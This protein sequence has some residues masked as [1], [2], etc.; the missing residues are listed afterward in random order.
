M[1]LTKKMGMMMKPTSEVICCVV[2]H[3]LFLPIALKLAEQMGKVYYWSPWDDCAPKV[4]K[5]I[6]GD[7]FENLHR[8][9]SIWDIK[10]ECD[11]FVFPDVGFAGLQKELVSQGYAVWGHH[12]ADELETKRGLFL[13]TLED[14]GMLVPDYDIVL[15][16]TKLREFLKDKEDLWI[17]ISRWRGDWETF[18]WRDW[19]H[20]EVTLDFY[21]YHFGPAKELIKFYVFKTIDTDI[22]DGID[23]YC[24]DDQ[25][26]KTVMHGME[27]KDK[28]YLCSIQLMEDVDERVRIVPEKFGPVLGKYGYRGFFSCEVRI[29]DDDSNFIDPTCR[30]A[31]PP[32]QVMTELFGNL[33]DIIWQGANGILVE[34]EP[35]AAFGVQALL[36][37]DRSKDEWVVLD[38]PEEIRQW[39]KCGFACE[40]DGK[41]CIPPH[42]LESMV[43]WLV[44]TGDSI[45]EAIDNL[46]EYAGQ[47]PDG[48]SCDVDSMA[49]LLKEAETAKEQGIELTEQEI[50]EPEVVL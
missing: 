1:T 16:L 6:I 43:G 33:G 42:P 22:E 45:E 41:I 29:K 28:S 23:T 49:H 18:H 10:S 48:V 40:I 21:A 46:K 26:P 5:G 19:E 2:D 13:D 39:V 50:P 11:L 4:E 31:S 17:K 9:E 24:I 3:G 15:G 37:I 47:L 7:G 14:V 12:G 36:T 38:V 27:C 35:T 30:A 34:P 32:S 25:F 8:V 44:A 20:D